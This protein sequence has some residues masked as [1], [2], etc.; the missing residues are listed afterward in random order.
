MKVVCIFSLLFVTPQARFLQLQ[1]S[2][3]LAGMLISM[4]TKEAACALS[5]I[6]P[7]LYFSALQPMSPLL[8]PSAR[9][10]GLYF[11]TLCH[12]DSHKFLNL[13]RK[14]AYCC[15]LPISAYN[16]LCHM[17]VNKS[18]PNLPQTPSQL[19]KNIFIAK[20]SKTDLSAGQEKIK[21]KRCC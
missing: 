13:H 12:Y 3:S 16:W 1:V 9:I 19:Q 17:R 20:P 18:K 7:C 11:S 15:Y 2:L 6:N 8:K 4:W 14:I 10:P 21:H 5:F